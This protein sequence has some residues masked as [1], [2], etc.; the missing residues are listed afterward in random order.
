M[1]FINF[2]ETL[3]DEEGEGEG[4]LEKE[5]KIN[6][7]AHNLKHLLLFA[8]IH[9][10]HSSHLRARELG[11]RAMEPFFSF[12]LGFRPC[13]SCLSLTSSEKQR[14]RGG[15]SAQIYSNRG[16]QMRSRSKTIPHAAWITEPSA[17]LLVHLFPLLLASSPSRLLTWR[18]N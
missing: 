4:T 5:M 14:E 11:R 18:E 7:R 3:E 2:A 9:S 8:A 12:V 1:R 13:S 16:P 6:T 10:H 17:E 15:K